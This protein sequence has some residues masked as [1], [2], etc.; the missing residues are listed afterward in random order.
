MNRNDN[1]FR[2][3]QYLDEYFQNQVREETKKIKP[4]HPQQFR[5]YVFPRPNDDSSYFKKEQIA[6]S[7]EKYME[8]FRMKKLQLQ[9]FHQQ[10]LEEPSDQKLKV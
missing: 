6:L 7:R 1:S 4:Y 2:L 8:H 3:K 9:L 10:L 5:L